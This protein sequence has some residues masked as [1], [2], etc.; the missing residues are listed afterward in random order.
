MGFTLKKLLSSFLM[1]LSIGLLLFILGLIYL[2]TSNY[3]KAKIYLSISFLWIFMVSYAPFSNVMLSPLESSHP[4]VEQNVSAKYILLLGGDFKGRS[5]EA[6]RLYHHIKGSKIITSGYPGNKAISEALRNAKKLIELGIPKKDILMQNQPRNT[7]EEAMNI[8][9]IVGN[10]QFIL[11]TSAYHMPRAVK[12]FKKYGLNPIVAPTNF[13]VE[14]S[15]L[16]T[17]P[18]GRELHKTEI[19]FHEYL[20]MAWNQ[21][22]LYK[23]QILH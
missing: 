12:L 23:K 9:Q 21:I 10:N 5:H 18:N 13:L 22:K 4:K 3:K 16:T 6:V 1:P 17:F 8:R 7:E 19:A 2:Y 11:I 20:G 14:K 15:K